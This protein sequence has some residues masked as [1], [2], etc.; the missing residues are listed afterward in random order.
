MLFPSQTLENKHGDNFTIG[1]L[2]EDDA[3]DLLAL[4]RSYIGNTNTIPIYLDEYP[5]D[6]VAEHQLIKRYNDS[7][8]SILLVAKHHDQL[9]GNIDLTGSERRIMFHTGMIGMGIAVQWRNQGI[10]TL[11][12]KTVLE[13][14]KE[15]SPLELIWLDVYANNE[16]GLGLHHKFGFKISGRIN[17]FF[18]KD[19]IYYDKIQMYLEL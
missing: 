18:K 17:R 5:E 8:N 10:G 4:K 9:I 16:L 15:A 13:W 6:E 1:C 7:P 3:P 11:L 19:G 14:A 2:S 12:L